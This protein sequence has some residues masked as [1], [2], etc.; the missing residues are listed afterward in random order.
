MII[1]R[2][3]V[4]NP[5][6]RK[7][8]TPL[9]YAAVNGHLD[10][11]Q[12]IMKYVKNKNPKNQKGETPY[13]LAAKKG[14]LKISEIISGKKGEKIDCNDVYDSDI[15]I[16]SNESKGSNDSNDSKRLERL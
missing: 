11:C 6:N 4:K 2:V 3:D 7:K 1:K 16:D 5:K 9:H 12:L 13:D 8:M 14:H 15:S 10:I